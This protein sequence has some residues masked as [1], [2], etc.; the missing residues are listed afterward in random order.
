[1]EK[2]Y[3]LFKRILFMQ[4]CTRLFFVSCLLAY[5]A[6]I[7]YYATASVGYTI[8]HQPFAQDKVIK[9]KV[10]NEEGEPLPGVTIVEKG[11][12]N[13][14]VS[15]VDGNFQLTVS[16]ADAVLVFSFV[17]MISQEQKVGN[18]SALN[19]T[20][21]EDTET[22]SE[23]VVVG[24]GTQEKRDVTGAVTSV[25][26]EEFNRGVINSPEQLLQGKV[27]GVNVTSAS[28][29]PGAVQG[30][31]IRGPGGV[32][33]GSTPLFVVDG[34][35]LDNS[36]TGGATNPLNF[37]NPQDIES[38]DVLKDASA[39]AIYGSRGANGVVLITTKKGKAGQSSIN[40][41]LGY[42]IST[43]ARPLDVFSADE[44][45]RQVS[46]LEGDLND[47]GANT[48][49]QEE[50]SRTAITQNHNLSFTGGADKL[51]YYA[52]LGLQDQEGVL[53]NSNLK[54][55]SARLNV[56]QKFLNDLLNVGLN[57][58][59]SQTKSERP[60]ISSIIGS[61]LSTNPTFPAYNENGAPYQY[62][63]GDNPLR[64]LE[65]WKD[66]TTTNRIIA[67]ITPSLTISKSLEYKLNLGVDNSSSVRDEQS[68]ASLVPQQDGRLLTTNAT[69]TNYLVENYL[70]Y[71]Y[72]N[73]DHNLTALAGHS[74]QKIF[75]QERWNSI[76]KFPISDIEPRYNPGM[77]Q[78]LTMGNNL[79][80][81][82]ALINELQSFF[83]RINYGY[84][85]RYLLT[86]TVR[87]DGS[88]KF[89]ENNK[90]GIFPSFS[91]GWRIS[92]ENFFKTSSF[93]SLLKL[94]AGWGQTG[95][96]EIPSKITQPLFTSEVT[97][98]TSYPLTPG[99]PYPAGTT[100]TRLANP[101]IQWEVST[102]TNIGLDFG[103]F[104]GALSGSV[105][106]FNKVSNNILLEVIPTDPVQPASTTWMN[107]EDMTITN[108]GLELAL[109]YQHTNPGGV[110]YGIGGN[111]TFIQNEV[112]NS[113]YTVIPSGSA[114]G[115]GLSSATIN[116]YVNGQP[117][118]TFYLQEHLGFDE[119]GLSIYRDVNEDGL[120]NDKDRVV[121]GSALPTRQY[122][123][124]GNI[125]FR[126]FDLAVNLNGVSGNKIYDNT[127]NAAFYKLRLSK[128]LNTTPEAVENPEESTNNSAPVSTRFLKD[129]SFLRLN[130][131]TL[132][133]NFNTSAFGIAKWVPKV[134]LSVTGQNLF[135]IT[136][137][138]GFDPEVNTD[139]TINGVSSYGIDYMSY[140]K[141]R[142]L[143]FGLNVTF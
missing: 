23:L 55:Y 130:N 14:T 109:N 26:S 86:A 105:D 133:Y 20:L 54:R 3:H 10:T 22:L 127:A 58:N 96:Q 50:I 89:G 1:M 132:G 126:G 9:G 118:G 25:Q 27:A 35:A 71:N 107:V 124:N 75:V 129:A 136:P 34:L 28:G 16:S 84:K 90:Y 94:R 47:M 38:I 18:R 70:T 42:G 53:R 93:V 119:A 44:F 49:W 29:E 77:G 138:D 125:A 36:S 72:L 122:N 120:I 76:N 45:R 63:S 24:Y 31:S 65:L 110:T 52:S 17:G 143:L 33:T 4:Y 12:V 21:A 106:V 128:G 87:A 11:T 135:V 39:T 48:D 19:V 32:R 62:E 80:G 100:Y 111:A 73:L 56:T 98:G 91:A 82:F 64:T 113:P 115:S 103:L 30:I 137:Y 81:G 101:D 85:D 46:A 69:N 2:L 61:A 102:Q 68:L 112:E 78:E 104:K 92:D 5:A 67:N 66:I 15:D 95:N 99:G 37:I 121:A 141:A 108:R 117:I 142:T 79:P 116:G 88:S 41:S 7:P 114:T 131:L 13:G 134:R 74:Y 57:L 139:R 59:A 8:N 43:M 83:G 40:Y 97:G 51:V 6:F 60:P 123:F 140:P